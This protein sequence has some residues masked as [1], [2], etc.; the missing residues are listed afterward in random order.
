FTNFDF[1]PLL[2][3][4]KKANYIE[5]FLKKKLYG[6]YGVYA[7]SENYKNT[8]SKEEISFFRKKTLL[9]VLVSIFTFTR[10]DN[11]EKMEEFQKFQ[12][13]LEYR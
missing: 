13:F 8:I 9:N 12:K 11:S 3:E 1:F 4:L 10:G 2:D 6:T 5:N 7:N